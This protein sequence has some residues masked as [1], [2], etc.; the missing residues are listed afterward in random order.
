M[1][2]L[3]AGCPS[4]NAPS[5]PGAPCTGG[6]SL[7]FAE[8]LGG[9]GSAYYLDLEKQFPVGLEINANHLRAATSGYVYGTATILHMGRRTHVWE[10]K[11]VDEEDKLV[12]ASRFTQA[13]IDIGAAE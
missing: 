13:I 4:T 8:T 2:S 12:C 1:D 6:A 3:K 5:N 10:I 7:A 11:I 9:V